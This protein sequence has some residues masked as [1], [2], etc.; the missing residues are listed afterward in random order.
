MDRY[1]NFKELAQN[2]TAFSIDC[3]DRG[4]DI[5][6]IAP[7]GG[8]IEPHTTEIATLIAGDEYNLYC[9]NGFKNNSNRD[10]HITSHRFDHN[11]ALR[12]I[13][14]AAVVIAIHGCTGRPSI[15]YL[16]GLD[17]R[18]I[19]AISY[20]LNLS[21]ISNT[22]ED[23]RYKGAHPENICNRGRRKQG[24]QL[25]IS[26]GVRDSEAARLKTAAAVRLAVATIKKRERQG[27]CLSRNR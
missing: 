25:E 8:N 24:V 20:R 21:Q 12:L 2:E 23:H 1:R 13:G 14:K 5:T 27:S 22:T 26:R 6:I 15:I 17:T 4:S 7:H 18:L 3:L 16:G 9:F 10:L 19:N 11:R